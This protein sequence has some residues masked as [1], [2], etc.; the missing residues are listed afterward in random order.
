MRWG[1][2]VLT[3]LLGLCCLGILLFFS[4]LPSLVFSYQDRQAQTQAAFTEEESLTLTLDQPSGLSF[5]EKLSVAQRQDI[6]SFGLDVNQMSRTAEEALALAGGSLGVIESSLGYEV[7]RQEGD[8]AVSIECYGW[9]EESTGYGFR[10]WFFAWSGG[11]G[12]GTP[13]TTL[14]LD[15]ETGLPLS[16]YCGQDGLSKEIAS[17]WAKAGDVEVFATEAGEDYVNMLFGCYYEMLAGNMALEGYQLESGSEG[18]GEIYWTR[19]RIFSLGAE[20]ELAE[21]PEGEPLEPEGQY[22][23]SAGTN[24]AAGNEASGGC[25]ITV[26]LQASGAWSIN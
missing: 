14:V 11:Y 21:A 10:V 23:S 17:R 1:K 26:R 8:A 24:A 12:A 22:D 16:I 2:A 5:L 9:I 3:A 18:E 20:T 7:W 15:D 4:Q 25:E 6:Q 19:F 13:Y